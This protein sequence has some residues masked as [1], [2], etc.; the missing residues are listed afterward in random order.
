MSRGA[1]RAST[2][3]IA[4]T[5]H[6][7]SRLRTCSSVATASAACNGMEERCEKRGWRPK[8]QWNPMHTL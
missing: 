1:A 8:P 7:R 6:K 4:Q 2:R 5:P 3:T